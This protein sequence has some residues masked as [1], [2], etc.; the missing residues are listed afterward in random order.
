[1]L[2]AQI[3]RE[4]FEAK[5]IPR[6]WASGVGARSPVMSFGNGRELFRL[7]KGF[8]MSLKMLKPD[9]PQAC[10]SRFRQE[11]VRLNH[12]GD[13]DFAVRCAVFDAYHAAFALNADTFS[14][15][16]FRR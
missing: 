7:R 15:S 4:C 2:A 8:R 1:M 9:C 11:L 14:E 10:V 5:N 13:G 12:R 16:N 3:P 6:N